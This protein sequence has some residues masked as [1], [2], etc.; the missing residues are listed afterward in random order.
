MSE[1]IP[2][3]P[4]DKRLEQFLQLFEHRDLHENG[5]RRIAGLYKPNFYHSFLVFLYGY[6]PFGHG[7][8]L[9]YPTLVV[10]YLA[11]KRGRISL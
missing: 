11:W 2:Q 6:T 8:I 9:F 10:A 7:I 3:E 1:H 4:M 5:E